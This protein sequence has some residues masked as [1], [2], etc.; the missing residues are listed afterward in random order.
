MRICTFEVNGATR[1][2][3]IA[4]D[5]TVAAI[6]D[7]VRGAPNDVLGLIAA[8][9][10]TWD[11]LRAAAAKAKGGTPLDRAKLR[12][13]IPVPRRNVFCVGWNYFSHFA[14]GEGKRGSNAPA[15]MPQHP[16]FFSKN[17]STVIGPD[18]GIR[19]PKPL[20]DQLDWEAELAVVIRG[21]GSHIPER[22]ALDHVFGY[23]VGNDV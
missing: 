22:D 20:S 16:S 1:A 18:A 3:M 15:E 19:H 9:P 23:T 4:G 14:E 8:G 10:A 17:P 6:A 21:P 13:P 7:L 5:N 11:R 2:G 12:A